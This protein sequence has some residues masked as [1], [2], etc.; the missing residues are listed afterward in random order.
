MAEED[1]S[2]S[3]C[4]G[5]MG[6]NGTNCIWDASL[7]T[8]DRKGGC[9]RWCR[10]HADRWSTPL[11]RAIQTAH[12]PA[13]SLAVVIDLL[14][15]A[16]KPSIF[17]RRGSDLGRLFEDAPGAGAVSAHSITAFDASVNI[18]GLCGTPGPSIVSQWESSHQVWDSLG[19]G[20]FR[21]VKR[22]GLSASWVPGRQ[23]YL[24]TKDASCTAEPLEIGAASQRV[25]GALQTVAGAK[26]LFNFQATVEG[27]DPIELLGVCKALDGCVFPNGSPLTKS[28]SGS[29]ARTYQF[30]PGSGTC[31]LGGVHVS[32]DCGTHVAHWHTL[33]YM[34]LTADVSARALSISLIISW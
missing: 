5:A 9:Q 18:C 7:C 27:W 31:A 19:L 30:D 28:V 20:T 1:Q 22:T 17:L 26:L 11:L 34:T 8:R 14:R 29:N 12:E 4:E 25:A 10:S 24:L 23:V 2:Q 3:A 33:V 13:A 15:Y 16:G 32:L 6:K 21:G